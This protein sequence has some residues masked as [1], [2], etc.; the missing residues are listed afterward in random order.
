LDRS[1]LAASRKNR[2]QQACQQHGVPA[3][4]ACWPGRSIDSVP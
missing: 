1:S 3:G 2:R 4:R